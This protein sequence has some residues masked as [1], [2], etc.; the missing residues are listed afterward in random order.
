MNKEGVTASFAP[1]KSKRKD[2]VP[3]QESDEDSSSENS[4]DETETET[5]NARLFHVRK[6]DVSNVTNVTRICSNT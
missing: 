4:S 3:R 2:T 1:V 5:S 6:R